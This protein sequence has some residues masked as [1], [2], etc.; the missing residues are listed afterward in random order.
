M[1]TN[2]QQLPFIKDWDTAKLQTVF[3]EITETIATQ[4][5]QLDAIGEELLR[6]YAGKF[7]DELK[8]NK[9][10][11]GEITR[12]VDG[13]KMTYAVKPKVKWDSDMLRDLSASMDEEVAERVFKVEYS[14]PE[15]TYK[16]ITDK[17]LLNA[18]TKAR[19]VEYSAPKITFAR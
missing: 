17:L 12:E 15:K 8:S 4:K 5:G 2:P 19:T 13:V 16:A 1:K 7:E 6:R 3:Q 14:V 10:V 9:Q 18:I 11:A